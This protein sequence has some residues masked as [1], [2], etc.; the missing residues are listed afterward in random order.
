MNSV[1]HDFRSA[2][3]PILCILKSLSSQERAAEALRNGALQTYKQQ[4]SFGLHV[5]VMMGTFYA[6]GHVAGTAMSPKT[7]VV[8]SG[9]I[10]HSLILDVC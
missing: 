10:V 9:F 7:S 3:L 5:I 1:S 8:S 4:I 6:V 2:T